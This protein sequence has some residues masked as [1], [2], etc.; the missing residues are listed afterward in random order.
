MHFICSHFQL[1]IFAFAIYL[2]HFLRNKQGEIKVKGWMTITHKGVK[3]ND[4]YIAYA[5]LHP[6]Y[7]FLYLDSLAYQKLF[8]SPVMC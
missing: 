3:I 7:I 8:I 6:V 1:I 5:K 4:I 2:L